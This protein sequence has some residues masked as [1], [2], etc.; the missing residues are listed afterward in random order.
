MLLHFRSFHRPHR[1]FR[2]EVK[3]SVDEK[4]DIPRI[5]GLFAEAAEGGVKGLDRVS[6]GVAA[7]DTARAS[8]TLY[9]SGECH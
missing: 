1:R 4:T 2:K 7:L 8:A 9:L 6:G 5:F 3:P